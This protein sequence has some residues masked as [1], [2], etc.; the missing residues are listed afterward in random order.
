MNLNPEFWY[1]RWFF[2]SATVLQV[3]FG[4]ELVRKVKIGTN[5]CQFFKVI[6]LGTLCAVLWISSLLQLFVFFI[7]MPL[8]FCSTMQIIS[9][10]S[11]IILFF[12]VIP[13]F[14]YCFV[15]CIDKYYTTSEPSFM[16]TFFEYIKSYKNKVCVSITFKDKNHV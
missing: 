13:L 4:N 8:V 12:V 2:W 7:V 3:I 15:Y 9:Y 5:L 11:V 6:F 14:F 16:S 10:L 1:V